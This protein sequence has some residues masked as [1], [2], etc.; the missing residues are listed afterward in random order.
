MNNAI[1]PPEEE[2]V[3]TQ[4]GEASGSGIADWK[5]QLGEASK[6]NKEIIAKESVGFKIWSYH[7]D[8]LLM[9]YF[10]TQA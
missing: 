3:A 4:E 6:E 7:A 1:G 5:S 2:L 9:E 8:T 10:S